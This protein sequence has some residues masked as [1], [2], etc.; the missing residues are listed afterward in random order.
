LQKD[1]DVSKVGLGR[2]DVHLPVTEWRI[3]ADVVR[4]GLKLQVRGTNSI[5]QIMVYTASIEQV[6][7]RLEQEFG[8]KYKIIM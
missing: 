8:S 3:K 2:L 7:G 4:G 5:Q 6:L 1:P